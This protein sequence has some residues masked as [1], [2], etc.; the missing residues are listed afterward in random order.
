[1]P[2]RR[3]DQLGGPPSP[4]MLPAPPGNI[5]R[6]REV[7]ISGPSNG[8]FVYNA[9]RTILKSSDVGQATTDPIL[10]IPCPEGFAT[11]N[12]AGKVISLL[13]TANKAFFQYADNPPGQGQ[14]IA[15]LASASGVD[16]VAGFNYLPGSYGLDPVGGS[17]NV[18]GPVVTFGEIPFTAF[19]R[20]APTIAPANNQNPYLKI[21]APEQ[22][23]SGHLQLLLQGSSPDGTRPGQLL[24]GQVATAG[25]LARAT[26]STIEA[27]SSG[28]PTSAIS[29]VQPAAFAGSVGLDTRISG[30]GAARA[31][32][33]AGFNS[34]GAGVSAGDGTHAHDVIL[35]RAAANQWVTT[36]LAAIQPGTTNTAES[37]HAFTGANG[38]AYAGSGTPVWGYRLLEN[39]DVE[40][41]GT[42]KIPVGFAANQQIAAPLPAGYRP[43][44]QAPALFGI[45]IGPTGTTKDIFTRFYL[46]TGGIL[47]TSPAWPGPVGAAAAGDWLVFPTQTYRLT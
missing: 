6:A 27:Q 46:D 20:I 34:A 38:W 7:I 47:T 3:V 11:Y 15:S 18:Q 5:I 12:A 9:A 39:G 19:A 16:P 4:G 41:S 36:L 43:A 26:G 10:G 24:L 40:V 31:C 17:F 2:A 32:L 28:N 14:L 30:D 25:T 21:D 13:S 22:G 42:V 1:L 35:I 33:T 44:N 29:G 45:I 23:N 8:Q 37:F